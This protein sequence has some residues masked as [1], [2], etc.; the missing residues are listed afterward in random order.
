MARTWSGIRN[1][2]LRH[3]QLSDTLKTER[4][5]RRLSLREVSYET[6]ISVNTLSR[7]DADPRPT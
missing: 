3:P 4:R 5:K 6:G 2:R 7:V 1:E